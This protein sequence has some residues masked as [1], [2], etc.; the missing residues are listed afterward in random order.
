MTTRNSDAPAKGAGVPYQLDTR[1]RW[2]RDFGKY[3][4]Y[5]Y[6]LIL[7]TPAIV[8]YL[9]FQYAPMYGL[10]I[11]FKDYFIRR[12]M[13]ASPWIGLENFRQL[14][15]IPSFWEVLRNTLII[16][17]MRITFSFPMPILF[18]ILL[19]ELWH[20][21]FKKVVQTISY[22]PH[23]LSWVVLGGLFVQFLSPSS[24][25]INLILRAMGAEPI[26]F[27]ADTE[28][29]RP[30]LIITG[31][32]KRVGWGSIVYLAAL[33][34]IDPQL[35]EA[36]TID[37]ANRFRRAI[38]ITLPSLAPV[39]TIMF[40]FAVGN[41]IQDDFDQIFNLY[42][43]AVYSVGD[44]LSTYMYRLGLLRMEYSFATAVGLFKNVIAF[45]LIV[46]TNAVTK[47]INE[48]GLW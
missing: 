26:Y 45:V 36:A 2:I 38:H 44:V 46:T 7:F 18:A 17:L 24:G 3:H 20:R 31:I 34:G 16:S 28:W 23:F 8:Y 10:Q 25:P 14:F 9:V 39:I 5:R 4:Q 22:L 42:N 6:L 37:G 12:G 41:I 21:R 43:P 15:A 19:N 27:L 1:P 48:Y 33:S 29:F 30:V 11:A 35:Y 13:W 40:I 32:W 47:R